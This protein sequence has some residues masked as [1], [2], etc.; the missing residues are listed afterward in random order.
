MRRVN[1]VNLVEAS[2]EDGGRGG[3]GGTVGSSTDINFGAAGGG[4]GARTA[5]TD[6]AN[7]TSRTARWDA[8]GGGKG[9]AGSDNV[10]LAPLVGGAGGGSGGNGARSPQD[11]RISA[12]AGGGGGGALRVQCAGKFAIGTNGILRAR[13]G[14]GGA[15][16]GSGQT[17]NA[18]PGGGGGGGSI[19]LRTLS[20]FEINEPGTAF[21]V[22]GGSGGTQTGTGTASPGGDG[23]EGYVR[24]EDPKGAV[25]VTVPNATNGEYNPVGA[26]VPSVIYTT[27]QDLGVTAPQL[28]NPTTDNFVLNPGNDAILIEIQ[29]AIEHP[30]N[31]GQPLADAIDPNQESTDLKEV[32]QWYPVRIVDN[33]GNATSAIPVDGYVK[34]AMGPDRLFDY[35]S[36]LNGRAFKFVR[37]RITFQLDD[38]HATGDPLPFVD[39]TE[40]PFLFNF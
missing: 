12:G 37:F 11:W 34:G 20:E 13:G 19:L 3:L 30:T 21:D 16:T 6:G 1:D 23:G 14:N 10:D 2:E 36:K 39:R 7:T 8:K 24:I 18:G 17:L 26:G 5:G 35:A 15:G 27:F 25:D 33:T 32:S 40:T 29:A 9:G 4:G 22:R 28:V 31:F 38:N